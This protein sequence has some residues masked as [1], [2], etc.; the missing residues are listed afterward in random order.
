MARTRLI[1]PALFA[2]EIL[3]QMDGDTVLLFTGLWCIAD[4]EGRI[5]DRP[6]RIKAQLFPY[7]DFDVAERLAELHSA[8][9][10]I[11]YESDGVM[12]IQVNNWQKHQRP[13]MKENPSE[14]PPL[15]RVSTGKT[16]TSTGKTPTS[17]GNAGPRLVQ[18]RPSPLTLNPSPNTLTLNPS[19]E[20][21]SVEVGKSEVLE[22]VDGHTD[23]TIRDSQPHKANLDREVC[24]FDTFWNSYPE[25]RRTKMVTV[26]REWLSMAHQRPAIEFIMAALGNHIA[27]ED[28]SRDGG[29]FVPSALNWISEQAWH[30][31]K[32]PAKK[33]AS[34][35]VSKPKPIP[36]VDEEEAAAWLAETYPAKAGTPF[37]HWPPNI[38]SEFIDI[39]KQ[40]TTQAA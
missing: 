38:Q 35:S 5:E 6:L 3:G 17:T 24:E 22:S 36:K 19:P 10:I 25:H 15:N 28:W 34:L 31:K 30:E 9:F 27:S 20:V 13:H 4:K 23:V 8:G 26:Q 32:A 29:K 14:L 11:R 33:S 39:A 2:N 18:E 16:Y 1:K 40:L 21:G 37:S 7:R 12:C